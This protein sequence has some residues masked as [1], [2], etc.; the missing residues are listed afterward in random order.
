H[1]GEHGDAHGV[2]HFGTRT[3]GQ[4]QRH[5][6]G[7]KGDRGHDDRAQPQ[8]AGFQRGADGV[9]PLQFEFTGELDDEDGV[10]A[11]QAHQHYQ[12]DLHEDV[13]IAVYQPHAKQRSEQTHG[14]DQDHRQRHY[15]AFIQRGEYQA[16]QQQGHRE[17]QHGGIALGNLLEAQVGPFQ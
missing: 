9:A 6:A 12:A 14:H 13:V 2:T 16:R 8:A 5:D 15:P 11:R 10:L 7:D 4:Y 17:D 3:S 1:A